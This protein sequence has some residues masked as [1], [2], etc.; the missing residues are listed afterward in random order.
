MPDAAIR[1]GVVD[2]VLPLDRIAAAILEW[3]GRP[4]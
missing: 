4:V 3:A 2:L 1:T